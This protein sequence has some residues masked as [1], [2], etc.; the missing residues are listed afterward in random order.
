MCVV[1]RGVVRLGIQNTQFI[2]ALVGHY[3]MTKRPAIEA[4]FLSFG[5]VSA[6][7]V[8]LLLRWCRSSLLV[9]VTSPRFL[10]SFKL[11]PDLCTEAQFLSILALCQG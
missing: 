1:N 6:V 11:V 4:A 10:Q 9:V 5:R 3:D 8:V 7:V 2:N